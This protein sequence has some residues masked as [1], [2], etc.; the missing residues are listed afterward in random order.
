MLSGDNGI[1]QRATD[2]KTNTERASVIEQAQTEILGQIAENKGETITETQL[3]AILGIYFEDF[4]DELPDD[5]SETTIT[6]TAKNEYGGYS[7]IA[8]ADIYNGKIVKAVT[9]TYHLI[10]TNAKSY[11]GNC[12]VYLYDEN[13]NVVPILEAYNVEVTPDPHLGIS[14]SGDGYISFVRPSGPPTNYVVTL[15][16]NGQEVSETFLVYPAG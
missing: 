5:L 8:L 12:I 2:A 1:L 3:K 7:N 11:S 15:T 10:S 4:D 13:D 9:H 14:F 6:L 16:I